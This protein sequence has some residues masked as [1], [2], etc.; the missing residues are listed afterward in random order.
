MKKKFLLFFVC[1][2]AFILLGCNEN[3]LVP[4]A[5]APQSTSV[6]FAEELNSQTQQLILD[7]DY[8]SALASI[9]QI[10]EQNPDD[11]SAYAMKVEIYLMAINQSYDDLNL[12]MA[13]DAEKVADRDAYLLA[14]QQLSDQYTVPLEIPETKYAGPVNRAGNLTANLIAIV[15]PNEGEARNHAMGT[16]AFQGD[17][18]F[19]ADYADNNALYRIKKDGTDKTKISSDDVFSINVIGEWVYYIASNENNQVY[20]V[21][22]NGNDRTQLTEDSAGYLYVQD[23]SVFYTNL[24]DNNGLYGINT[25]GDDITPFGEP[26]SVL[27]L[28]DSG[29]IFSTP[30]QSNLAKIDNQTGNLSYIIENEWFFNP[31]LYDN[32]VYFIGEGNGNPLTI[33]KINLDSGERTDVFAYEYKINYYVIV[34]ND[35]IVHVRDPEGYEFFVRINLDTSKE[36]GR[37]DGCPGEGLCADDEGNTYFVSTQGLYRL[38]WDTLSIERID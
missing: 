18:L 12:M 5:S 8:V 13:E 1:V 16:F 10:L 7:G 32:W 21:K 2:L 33:K 4:D 28:D 27:F 29:I 23:D 37:I 19:Y 31:Q 26:A 17:T 36:E 38:D 34:K 25:N 9:E 11:V 14:L 30:D 3:G 35:L 24:N 22:T 20:K 15:W 6:L